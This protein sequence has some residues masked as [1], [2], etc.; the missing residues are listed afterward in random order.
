LLL[1]FRSHREK[2]RASLQDFFSKGAARKSREEQRKEFVKLT[3]ITIDAK[4][5]PNVI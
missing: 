4:P 3:I 5:N 2:E 1:S